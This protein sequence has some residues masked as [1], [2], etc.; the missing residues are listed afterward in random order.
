[1]LCAKKPIEPTS[2]WIAN[3]PEELDHDADQRSSVICDNIFLRASR[4]RHG[5]DF[6]DNKYN[7]SAKKNGSPIRHEKMNH[8]RQR[9]KYN[10][11]SYQQSNKEE[12]M[13]VNDSH[14]SFRHLFALF[15]FALEHQLQIESTQRVKA[16]SH[17]RTKPSSQR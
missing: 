14:D 12:M 7:K 10:R 3:R 17:A 2:D 9:L 11:V 6:S 8:Q 16:D 15:I 4:E 1:M 5:D 13:V